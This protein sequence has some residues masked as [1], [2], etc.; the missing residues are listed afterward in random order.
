MTIMPDSLIREGMDPPGHVPHRA[1]WQRNSGTAA[2]FTVTSVLD[3][4]FSTSTSIL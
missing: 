1:L 4:F 3:V 2:R